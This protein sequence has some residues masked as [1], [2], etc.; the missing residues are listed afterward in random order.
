MSG[1]LFLL[2]VLN[3]KIDKFLD[4]LSLVFELGAL[5]IVNFQIKLFGTESS[6]LRLMIPVISYCC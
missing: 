3:E 5:L 2:P 1:E 6:V 4:D